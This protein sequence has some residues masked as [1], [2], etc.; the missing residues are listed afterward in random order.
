MTGATRSRLAPIAANLALT[1]IALAFIGPMLW[2]FAAAFNPTA[3]LSFDV[4]TRPT[5]DNFRSVATWEVLFRPLMNSLVLSLTASAVTVTAACFC[6]Y[7]LSRLK[8]RFGQLFL[9]LILIASGLPVI[10]LIIP[11]YRMFTKLHLTDHTLAT[12]LFLSGTSLPFAIWL[13]KNSI[14]AVP[15][16]LEEAARIDGANTWQTITRVV[17]PLIRPG[18]VVI[19]IF[20]FV[21]N[22]G[23]FFVPYILF[24]DPA[25]QTASV[26]IYSFFNSLGGVYFGRVAAFAILYST[27]AILLYTV[28]S[29]T[30]GRSF[31]FAGGVKG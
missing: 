5:L 10:A 19:F 27:P 21:A 8:L 14:D 31:R 1:A 23:N 15:T 6:A 2:M 18:I 16:E 13:A 28:I 11:T 30:L 9:Y 25:K 20:T 29:R 3:Q 4:P 7:P 26:T 12:A 24:T 22:W 17:V